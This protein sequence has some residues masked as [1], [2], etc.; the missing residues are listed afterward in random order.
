MYFHPHSREPYFLYKCLTVGS[1]WQCCCLLLGFQHFFSP[2]LT[3][4]CTFRA[5][6]T[7][8]LQNREKIHL[9]DGEKREKGWVIASRGGESRCPLALQPWWKRAVAAW[10]LRWGDA[11]TPPPANAHTHTSSESGSFR[12]LLKPSSCHQQQVHWQ[13]QMLILQARPAHFEL[14]EG[15][16]LCMSSAEVPLWLPYRFCL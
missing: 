4:N 5:Y 15:C 10:R 8:Q 6:C 13:A 3:G 16:C 14:A 12:C 9:C 11:L 7:K 2:L 1:S